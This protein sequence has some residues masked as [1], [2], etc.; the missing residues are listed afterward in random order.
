MVLFDID[1]FKRINDTQGH[2]V[3]DLMLKQL[4]SL[5]QQQ[6]QINEQFG[7]YGGDE[8]LILVTGMTYAV[9]Q[10]RAEQLRSLVSRQ[11]G[12]TLSMGLTLYLPH[13]TQRLILQRADH[14]LYQA[15]SAGRNRICAMQEQLNESISA[16]GLR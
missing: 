13:D 14:A 8:F 2:Q 16:I 11:L 3:G 12:I 5:L 15:K 4:A 6:M 7:R 9:L 1:C 10:E